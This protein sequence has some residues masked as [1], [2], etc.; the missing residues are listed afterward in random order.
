[1]SFKDIFIFDKGERRALVV[2]LAIALLSSINLPRKLSEVSAEE[3]PP[4]EAIVSDTI[5]KESATQVKTLPK[6]QHQTKYKSDKLQPGNTVDLNKCDTTLL[7]RVPGIGSSYAKRIVAYRDLLGGYAEVMQL[8]EIY[9]MDD[10][11]Y[12]NI[13]S[14]F[15][16]SPESIL[17]LNVNE[18]EFKTLL[19]HPYINIDQ[20]KEIFSFRNKKKKI[21]QIEEL[22]DMSNFTESDIER[23]KPYLSFE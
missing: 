21:S 17:K 10:E 19:R 7:K 14:W 11:K 3:E 13:S 12:E 18:A 5:K 9:G 6:K 2:L 4:H 22:L 20:T 15:V 16:V 1:M 23:L 8:K